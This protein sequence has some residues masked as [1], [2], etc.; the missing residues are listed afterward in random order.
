[1]LVVFLKKIKNKKITRRRRRSRGSTVCIKNVS[2]F[3]LVSVSFVVSWMVFSLTIRKPH[4][5]G[6]FFFSSFFLLLFFFSITLNNII[7][8]TF[9]FILLLPFQT[10]L[11]TTRG[12]SSPFTITIIIIIIN[13][14][15]NIKQ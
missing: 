5:Y 14:I 11:S 4:Q 1:M 7:N 6:F 13:I 8:S 10:P 15:N 2:V 9:P 12:F 3:Q